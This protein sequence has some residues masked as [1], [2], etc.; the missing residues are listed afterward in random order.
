LEVTE[1][2]SAVLLSIEEGIARIV[3]DRPD[4]GNKIGDDFVAGFDTATLK[5]SERDDIRAAVISATGK[6]FSVGGDISAMVAH[7]DELPTKIRRWNASLQDSLA[8]LDRTDDAWDRLSGFLEKRSPR[9][10]GR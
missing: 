6:R 8:R 7:R 9:F 1:M 2:Q 3:F 5:C 10:A 4:Q